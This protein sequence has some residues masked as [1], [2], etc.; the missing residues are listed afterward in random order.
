MFERGVPEVPRGAERR[1]VGD[2]TAL[3]RAC[4]VVLAV[5]EAVVSAFRVKALF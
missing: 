5:P 2:V 3:L 1:P 4:L